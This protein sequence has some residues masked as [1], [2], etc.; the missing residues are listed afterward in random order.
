[1]LRV[2]SVAAFGVASLSFGLVG[3]QEMPG[4]RELSEEQEVALLEGDP[5]AEVTRNGQNNRAELVAIID[6]PPGDVWEVVI[7]YD[8]YEGWFPDQIVADIIER[9]DGT[10][11]LYGETR[12]PVLRNRTYR[13]TEVRRSE[14]IDGETV[15]IDEWEY[16][17]DSG[18]L[19]SSTGFWYITP[20]GDSGEQTLVR[21]V[22]SADLGIWL[23]Q[24]LIN[25]GTRRM[26]PGIAEGIQEQVDAR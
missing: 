12:V 10:G 25:W 11:V 20:Y 24:T 15:F 13:L 9:D 17:P 1:M 5:I 16:V 21:M 22:V 3:A 19:D 23:P 26:L 14:V 2:V 8:R 4:P 7:A 18:N 6:A